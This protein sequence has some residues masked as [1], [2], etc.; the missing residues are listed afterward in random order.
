M[1]LFISF[2]GVFIVLDITNYQE[3]EDISTYYYF[4][5]LFI[6]IFIIT[7]YIGRNKEH[8]KTNNIITPST[9]LLIDTNTTFSLNVYGLNNID[10]ANLINIL[11]KSKTARLGTLI[12]KILPY[13]RQ[14]GFLCNEIEEYIATYKPY[15]FDKLNKLKETKAWYDITD[16]YD[17]K[18]MLC[19]F[20][21]KALNSLNILPYA[22]DIELLFEKDKNNKYYYRVYAYLIVHTYLSGRYSYETIQELDDLTLKYIK[23]WEAHCIDDGGCCDYC[24][25]MAAKKYKVNQYPRTPFHIGCRCTTLRKY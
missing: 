10:L 1:F 20:K 6:S 17:K 16:K 8:T 19:E 5:W 25:D 15:Y 22:E 7:Y 23:G 11:T 21:R 3:P 24:K 13:V 12:N 4:A 14:P 9:G 2:I 18:E